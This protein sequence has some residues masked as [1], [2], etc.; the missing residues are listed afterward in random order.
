MSRCEWIVCESTNRWASALRVALERDSQPGAARIRL[1]E[2]RQLGDL[3]SRLGERPNSFVATEVRAG[4]VADV[5]GWLSWA[6][7]RFSRARFAALVDRSLLEE[8]RGETWS[9]SKSVRDLC[10]ALREAGALEVA[11]SPRQLQGVLE[12]A[13]QQ[14]AVSS[15]ASRRLTAYLSVRQQVW[16]ALPWQEGRPRVG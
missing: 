1:Y 6:T 14:W 16:D 13:W 4:N 3:S 9:A 2:T 7:G 11:R 8:R 12:L 15:D 5:L 10:D